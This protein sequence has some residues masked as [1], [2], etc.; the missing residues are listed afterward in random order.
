MT[1]RLFLALLSL[2]LMACALRAAEQPQHGHGGPSLFV[3]QATGANVRPASGSTATATGAFT[4]DPTQRT[5]TYDLTYHGLTAP[6]RSIALHNFGDGGNGER[7]HTLCGDGA[8]PC[9]ALPSGNLTGAWGSSG[10][11]AFDARLLGEFASGR[12][13]AEVIGADGKPAIRGQLEPNGAM[14]PVKNYVAHLTSTRGGNGVG[15]AIL[16]ETHFADGR[17]AVFYRLTV[18]GTTSAPRLVSLTGLNAGDRPEATKFLK[19]NALPGLRALS[20]ATATAGGT[21]IGSYDSKQT[22]AKLATRM[23]SGGKA[24]V[25]ITVT[26]ARF[27]DGELYGAFRPVK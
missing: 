20:P 9:P 27:P 22:D 26:T 5:L 7:V 14:V 3:V 13:Y 12:V 16:S 15:T 11:A 1:N 23:L 25:G 10:Q 2:P 4:I 19:E 21:L 17:V 18:T 8:S 6:P 24:E